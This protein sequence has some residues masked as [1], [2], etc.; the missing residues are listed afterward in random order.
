MLPDWLRQ[1]F[2]LTIPEDRRAAFIKATVAE[3]L[4]RKAL[5]TTTK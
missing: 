1:R 3:Y 2:Y 5:L 4:R